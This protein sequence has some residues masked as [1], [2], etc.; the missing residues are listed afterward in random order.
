MPTYKLLDVIFTSKSLD[1]LALG[2]FGAGI[3]NVTDYKDSY[4]S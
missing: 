4:H 2:M 1:G 3:Y